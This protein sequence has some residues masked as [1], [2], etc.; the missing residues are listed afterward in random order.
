MSFLDGDDLF[1][2]SMLEQMYN[3]AE[4]DKSDTVICEFYEYDS[5][6][7][8]CGRRSMIRHTYS[9]K[10]PFSPRT[11]INNV[12]CFS[13][14]NAW[15]KLF[16]RKMFA[17]NNIR[18]STTVCCN[19]LAAVCLALACSNKISIINTPFIKYRVNQTKNLTAN[20]N[21]SV[22]S[23]FN[24]IKDL[25]N[26]LKRLNLYKVFEN[27]YR[28]RICASHKWELSL[29]NE[30]QKEERKQVAKEILPD[31]IYFM[32]YNERK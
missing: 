26:N 32:L 9:S 10:S 27:A 17:D 30:E 18:F 1:D 3:K 7:N 28:L 11:F 15:T 14:S 20:R 19:D 16:R 25:Q 13:S 5:E 22:D 4:K 8:M 2:L 21:K 23:F 24:A 6:T 29:C 31:D 12:F